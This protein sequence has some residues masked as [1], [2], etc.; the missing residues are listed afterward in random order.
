MKIIIVDRDP[1]DV[2]LLSKNNLRKDAAWIPTSVCD[3]VSYYKLL[4]SNNYNDS[5]I[6]NLQFEDLVYQYEN[7]SNYRII[8]RYKNRCE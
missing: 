5:R 8:F 6:Y 3:F 4:R 1:R 2:Y 7:K